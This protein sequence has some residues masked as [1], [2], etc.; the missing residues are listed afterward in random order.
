MYCDHNHV[1]QQQLQH[2]YVTA[3]TYLLI[4]ASLEVSPLLSPPPAPA[5]SLNVYLCVRYW[6]Q[7]KSPAARRVR[8]LRIVTAEPELPTKHHHHPP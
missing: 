8:S 5:S 2:W 6:Q 3:S 1:Y 7:C 4:I